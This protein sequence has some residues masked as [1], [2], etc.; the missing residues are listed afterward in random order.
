ML[1]QL[2]ALQAQRQ[3]DAA[4]PTAE[5]A[6]APVFLEL[7]DVV[8]LAVANNTAVRNAYLDRLVQRAARYAE[9]GIYNPDLTPELVGRLDSRGADGRLSETDSRL[10]LGAGVAMLLPTGATANLNWRAAL[11]PFEPEQAVDLTF[12]QPLLRDRGAAVT[13]IPLALARLEER[14][15]QLRFRR[16]LT[17][18]VTAAIANYRQLL[19]AQEEVKARQRSL[20]N[21]ERNL[22]RQQALVKAGRQARYTLLGLQQDVTNAERLLLAA[23]NQVETARLEL[24]ARLSIEA[25]LNLVASEDVTQATAVPVADELD[26]ETLWPLAQEQRPDYRERQL[27]VQIA[28][29]N[30]RAAVNQRQWRLDLGTDYRQTPANFTTAGAQLQLSRNLG[31]RRRDDEELQRQQAAVQQAQ[32][33]LRQARNELRVEVSAAIRDVQLQFAQIELA[34][35]ALAAAEA[36]L[37]AQEAFQASGRGNTTNLQ[38]AQQQVFAQR[39]VVIRAQIDYLNALAEL[40]RAVG[41]TP[42]R[43]GIVIE[44]NE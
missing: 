34:Q 12:Q 13:E 18:V 15:Q 33:N 16:T 43:W 19:Q 42:I 8:V 2:L 32:N 10:D 1:R 11:G 6:T 5:P 28:S 44:N 26:F 22:A 23:R 24:L 41:S 3:L 17:Q 29:L 38:Q 9:E 21:A 35:Q 4:T 27:A 30:R 14:R 37:A 36:N 7:R 20:A 31:D 39:Q 40:D 25:D